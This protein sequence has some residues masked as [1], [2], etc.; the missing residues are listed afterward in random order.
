M[1]AG[2]REVRALA[3]RP[4]RCRSPRRR[5]SRA[6]TR[7]RPRSTR[8]PPR[9]R[10]SGR[11][12]GSRRAISPR[13]AMRIAA[14]HAQASPPGRRAVGAVGRVAS[15]AGDGLDDR[16][17]LAVLD[18]LAGLGEDLDQRA[19]DRAPSTSCGMPS[20][21]TTA[22]RSPA[23]TAVPDGDARPEDADGGRGRD[24]AVGRRARQRPGAAADFAARGS[25]C[26][27]RRPAAGARAR[28]GAGAAPRR[29]RPP[30]A[31]P[32]VALADLELAQAGRR[33]ASATSAGTSVSDRRARLAWSACALG[34]RAVAG[35]VRVGHGLD[36]LAGGWLLAAPHRERR[37]GIA[38][39][40]A[41]NRPRR[42]SARPG[43]GGTG[44]VGAGPAS[45]SNA[46]SE[47]YRR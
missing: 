7:G 29:D 33:S 36:V 9:C 6:A 11:R 2:R 3:R 5:A 21:S 41:S 30:E 14:D 42:R 19:V 34:G 16:D 17:L 46:P 45:S 8:R 39:W 38:R 18:G 44:G 10:A 43:R 32:P 25:A 15:A 13:L 12:A 27:A 47:R 20:R 26:E 28:R 22:I 37:R 24:R 1:I 35:R 40:P 31:D 23:R 4:G